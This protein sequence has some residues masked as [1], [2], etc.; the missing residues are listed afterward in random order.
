MAIKL[1]WHKFTSWYSINLKRFNHYYKPEPFQSQIKSS[2]LVQAILSINTCYHFI[3]RA[4]TSHLVLGAGNI[5]FRKTTIIRN[6]GKIIIYS[7]SDQISDF[8][9]LV[10]KF[11][12][13]FAIP[14]NKVSYCIYTC[15]L[16][17]IGV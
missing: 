12:F 14:G 6:I 13:C 9:K 16:L 8:I 5:Q 1:P 17:N 10:T 15:S 11:N 4:L 7:N 2:K 3:C